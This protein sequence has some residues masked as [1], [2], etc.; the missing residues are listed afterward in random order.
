MPRQLDPCGTPGAYARHIR[1]GEKPDRAC[2]LADRRARAK[3]KR[4]A[5]QRARAAALKALTYRHRSEYRTLILQALAEIE[6]A[7]EGDP[8]IAPRDGR[9]VPGELTR[10]IR[11]WVEAQGHPVRLLEIRAA[12]SGRAASS[13]VTQAVQRMRDDGRLT[14]VSKGVYW[15]S[16]W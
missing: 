13:A 7:G 4:A 5:Y 12:F 3:R 2:R 8:K 15:I 16:E 14:R 11:L 9:R 6:E 10:S 1:H